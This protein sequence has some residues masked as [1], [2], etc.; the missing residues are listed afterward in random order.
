MFEQAKPPIETTQTKK[1]GKTIQTLDLRRWVEQ[2]P[3]AQRHFRQAVH[4][5]LLAIGTSNNLRSQ[6]VMKGGMLMAIRYNS[7]RFTK[8]AD[9]ST[10]NLYQ[11]GDEDRLVSQLCEAIDAVNASTDYDTM[12]LLQTAKLRPKGIVKTFPTLTISVG[13]AARS[14]PR[15]LQRLLNKQSPN[16]VELDC[17]FNEAILDAE[18]LRLAD[19]QGLQVYSLV[20]LMAEKYRSL[21]QQPIRNRNRRQDVYDLWLL[22]SQ[23]ENFSASEKTHLTACIEASCATK[24]IA[25]TRNSLSDPVVRQMSCIGLKDLSAEVGEDLPTF[26]VAYEAL[27]RFFED[28]P[29]SS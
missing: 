9:F 10:R 4:V 1:V 3:E 14:Q 8:D 24:N 20:N 6:M 21:L 2:A 7:L 23:L 16:V 17:S 22:I 26:D 19:G 25:A 13:Y 27:E 18:L 12:C 15:A 5:V 11:A 29:W 28:L